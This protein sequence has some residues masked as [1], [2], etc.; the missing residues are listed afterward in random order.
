MGAGSAKRAASLAHL[1]D[2]LQPKL[3]GALAAE[4]SEDHFHSDSGP[5][6]RHSGKQAAAIKLHPSEQSRVS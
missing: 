4:L 5:L 3:T 6:P 2:R 1:V